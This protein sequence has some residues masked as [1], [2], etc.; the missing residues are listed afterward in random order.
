MLDTHI[1]FLRPDVANVDVTWTQ[2]GAVLNG[3]DMGPRRGL[4]MWVVTKERG[5]WAISVMHNMD[6]PLEPPK[7]W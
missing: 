2:T 1:R 5:V 7:A 3:K 6:L 4:L